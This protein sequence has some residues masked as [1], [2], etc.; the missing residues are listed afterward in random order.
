MPEPPHAG[1]RIPMLLLGGPGAAIL[2]DH[3]GIISIMAFPQP[4]MHHAIG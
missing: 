2:D 1:D 3:T 4:G